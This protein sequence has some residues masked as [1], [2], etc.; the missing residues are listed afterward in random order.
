MNKAIFWHLLELFFRL[1]FYTYIYIYINWELASSFYK[2][3]SFLYLCI[4]SVYA[5]YYRYIVKLQNSHGFNPCC[6]CARVCVGERDC[7]RTAT[8]VVS[9]T[10]MDSC[11]IVWFDVTHAMGFLCIVFL[12]E[13]HEHHLIISTKYGLC[14]LI[15]T[16]L[17]KKR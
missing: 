6:V 16:F 9:L 7:V 8:M 10:L 5:I 13:I 1:L 3:F 4:G 14:E 12:F 2:T 15:L 17:S 11:R